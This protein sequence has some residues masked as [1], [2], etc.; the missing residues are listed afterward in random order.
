MVETIGPEHVVHIVTDNGANYKRACKE[1]MKEYEHIVWT[2]CLAHTVNLI[3]KDIGERA[4]HSGI[5]H[6]CKQISAF[7]HNHSQ[8]YA[9]MKKT[10]GGELVKWNATRFGTNYMFLDSIYRRKD[11]FMQW[12]SSSEFTQSK[13]VRTDMGR[14]MHARFTSLEWWEG[15]KYIID[16]VQPVYRLLRFADQDKRPNLCELVV[17]YQTMR[18]EMES[19][20]SNNPSTWR[21]YNAILNARIRDTY[22]D[23]TYVGAGMT[24]H[25]NYIMLVVNT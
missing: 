12:M 18:N 4:D 24:S 1:L 13:W 7:L 10:I 19:F 14:F 5:I 8:L 16:T 23:S 17:N 6:I 15:M 11:R 2:P 22:D 9:M 21:E 20:F 25:W 3:L